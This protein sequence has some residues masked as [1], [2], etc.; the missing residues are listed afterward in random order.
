MFK[1][2]FDGILDICKPGTDEPFC[3]WGGTSEKSSQELVSSKSDHESNTVRG[4][5]KGSAHLSSKQN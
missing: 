2:L 4:K 3:Q 1:K 5:E